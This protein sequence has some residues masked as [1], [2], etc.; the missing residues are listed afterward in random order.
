MRILIAEDDRGIM[1]TYK[2]L[3]G[4]S[5]ELFTAID[6]EKAITIFDE[7]SR[8]SGANAPFDLV[9]LDYRM[10]GRN[11]VEVAEHILSVA[12][13]QKIIIASAYTHE[14]SINRDHKNISMLQ[15]P[16]EIDVLFQAVESCA[17]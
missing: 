6:G 11:G 10:P 17:R 2:L 5:H 4:S 14:L 3:L 16:F 9:M 1:D 7:E 13:S 8:K 15:K 12:P